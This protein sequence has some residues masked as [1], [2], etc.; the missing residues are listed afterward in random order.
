LCAGLLWQ[1]GA[2]SVA[3]LALRP[4]HDHDGASLFSCASSQD[5]C[6]LGRQARWKRGREGDACAAPICATPCCVLAPA[7]SATFEGVP[8]GEARAAT[9]QLGVESP[10][11]LPQ[12][13]EH[14]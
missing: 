8:K 10:A 3:W 4:A 2:P 11:S 1:L 13:G 7:V 9:W 6:V 5:A 12:S 14:S